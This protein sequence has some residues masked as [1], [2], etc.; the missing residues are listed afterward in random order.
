MIGPFHQLLATHCANHRAASLAINRCDL[1]L[2]Q[3]NCHALLIYLGAYKSSWEMRGKYALVGKIWLTVLFLQWKGPEHLTFKDRL[4]RYLLMSI[5]SVWV[6]AF[7]G[8]CMFIIL[9]PQTFLYVIGQSVSFP[10]PWRKTLIPTPSAYS[11]PPPA[12]TA[13][14]SCHYLTTPTSIENLLLLTLTC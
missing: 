14:P 4:V 10:S 6:S 11:D 3:G 8:K 12:L 13:G 2:K 9:Y 1:I 7:L 5:L